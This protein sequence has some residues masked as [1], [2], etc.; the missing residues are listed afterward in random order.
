MCMINDFQDT[1]L[2][3]VAVTHNQRIG[4]LR[5]IVLQYQI[6]I[7]LP[8]PVLFFLFIGHI[9]IYRIYPPFPVLVFDQG[10]AVL[11]P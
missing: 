4:I 8:D 5:M 10:K 7:L 11:N 2:C 3:N 6:L 9:L 1:V